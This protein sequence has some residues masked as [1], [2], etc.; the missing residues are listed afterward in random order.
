[1]K[2]LFFLSVLTLTMLTSC[3]NDS[4]TEDDLSSKPLTAAHLQKEGKGLYY[5]SSGEVYYNGEIMVEDRSE[6]ALFV[7]DFIKNN[8]SEEAARGGR[9]A[10]H[11]CSFSL[12]GGGSV[13]LT[14]VYGN[15]QASTYWITFIDAAGVHT[16]ENPG[17]TCSEV[18]SN[19][20]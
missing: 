16:Y 2:K 13:H 6:M 15:G 19:I 8:G 17:M 12:P 11:Q 5:V 3:T 4:I 10:H 9:Q 20:G 14:Q 7:Q 1:M 18:G